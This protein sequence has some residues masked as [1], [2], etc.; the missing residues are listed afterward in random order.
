MENTLN[1]Y[2]THERKY[3]RSGRRK[4]STFLEV[5]EEQKADL[6]R[7]KV[8]FKPQENKATVSEESYNKDETIVE[9]LCYG[10]GIDSSKLKRL[11]VS[12]LR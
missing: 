10:I 4:L 5:G 9:E 12:R 11:K 2:Q 1:S 8:N 3:V 6:R 7:K